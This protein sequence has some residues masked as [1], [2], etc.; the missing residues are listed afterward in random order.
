MKEKIKQLEIQ[1]FDNIMSHDIVCGVRK[2]KQYIVIDSTNK[3]LNIVDISILQLFNNVNCYSNPPT[4][5]FNG[6]ENSVDEI[7][8]YC[9]LTIEY[10]DKIALSM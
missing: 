1:V 4:K 7:D 3:N 6:Q 5:N 2:E 10:S 8:F 9:S